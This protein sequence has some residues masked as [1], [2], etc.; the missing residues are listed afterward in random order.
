MAPGPLQRLKTQLYELYVRAHY[1]T[2]DTMADAVAADDALAG[3]PSRDSIRRY[4]SGPGRPDEYADLEALVTVLARAA[5]LDVPPVLA[6]AREHWLQAG[7][8][9]APAALVQPG[10]D[11]EVRA[12][13]LEALRRRYRV[14]ELST[15]TPEGLDE[16]LPIW[17]AQVFEPQ[18]VR[19]VPER[20]HRLP[21]LELPRDLR[22]RLLDSGDLTADELP[23]DLNAEQLEEARREHKRQ[24]A[25]PVLQALALAGGRAV[26]LGDPGAGKSTLLAYLALALAD[27]KIPDE[28]T[29]WS[30]R[31][32]LLVELREYAD[33]GWRIGRWAD[34]TLLDFLDHRYHH[35]G[36]GLP[37]EQLANH[38]R[39]DGRA[40]V[41]FDGLDELFDPAQRERTARAIAEFATRYPYVTVLVTSRPI[42]YQRGVLDAAR[43]TLHTVE[44]L[45]REQIT[46][47]VKRWYR[48]SHHGAP[49]EADARAS[50]LCAAL[51][52]SRS[53]ASLAGNPLLLTIL[54]IIGRRRELPR[55]RHRVYEHAVA[56][57]VQQWD[58]NRHLHDTRSG[59]ELDDTDRHRLLHRIAEHMQ[60]GRYGIAGNRIHRE[61]L[62]TTIRDYLTGD[63]A[64]PVDRSRYAG[65]VLIKQLRERNFILSRYGPGLFGFVHRAFLEYCTAASIT[66]RLKEDQTLSNEELAELFC[67]HATDPA[68]NEIL[69]LVAGMVHPNVLVPVLHRLLEHV[70]SPAGRIGRHN[71]QHLALALDCLAETRSITA[72]GV[73]GERLTTELLRSIQAGIEH[74]TDLTDYYGSN[75]LI[76]MTENALLELKQRLPGAD[77]LRAQ[78]PFILDRLRPYLTFSD[79][80]SLST[81]ERALH[82]DGNQLQSILRARAT[83]SDNESIQQAAVRALAS[84]WPDEHTRTWLTDWALTD[85]LQ[86]GVREATVQALASG[87]PDDRTRTLLT[88]RATTD[89]HEYV[90]G[91][92]VQELASNWP[93][94]RTRTLLTDR[95]TTDNHEYVR[96]IAVHEL[97][98]GWPDNHSRTLLTDRATTDNH[99]YVRGTAMQA[100]ASGWPDNHTRTLL[101]DRATT[102]NHEYVRATAMQELASGWPDNH[103]RTLLTDRATT[104]NHE[105]VRATAVQ[106][107]ASGWPDNHTRTLLTDQATTDT[108]EDVRRTA[109]Q[110]LASGWPDD[111]TRTLLTDRAIT[112][113]HEFVRGIAI[114]ELASGWPD[115]HTRTLLTDQATTDTHEDVRQTALQVL[116]SGWPDD[117]TRTLLTDR[118]TTDNDDYVR[119]TALRVLASGWPDDHTRTLLTDR[120]TTDN[121]G[122][123]R[124]TAVQELGSGWPDDHTR[125]LL[126]DRATTDDDEHVRYTATVTLRAGWPDDHTRALLTDRATTDDDRDVQETAL[127]ALTS[128]WPDDHTRALL[129]DRA[130]TDNHEDVRRRALRVLASGW[131]DDHTRALLIDRATTDNHEDVRQTAL[132]VLASG[133]PDDHTRALLTDRATTD[134]HEDAQDAAARALKPGWPEA[135]PPPNS[136]VPGAC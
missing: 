15:L 115:N 111:H 42:G 23:E 76:G 80:N 44:D 41:M 106:E 65:T 35:D 93:D 36:L 130:T 134:N 7:L 37:R 75:S 110:V 56:V 87:W 32:P 91:T 68:W 72:L 21:Q 124:Q 100:L 135:V 28:L 78:I 20:A 97:A 122:D 133:W 63:C 54:A 4:I 55:E 17:L 6:H 18:R 109:L 1:P 94:N 129:T 24:P 83:T 136:G 51:D 126:T 95:A 125:T 66:Y 64:Q 11:P 105:D 19:A 53:A 3:A 31:L 34:A 123:V 48:L 79:I 104:D 33:P 49:D 118:A 29:S 69:R 39:A 101:T 71:H 114:Q 62:L 84:G 88:D 9:P 47:F 99:E 90:R 46:T 127:Q 38:L 85:E 103:T 10:L 57:L 52:R 108:H 119:Q 89:N 30:G 2:L 131:P 102:D 13:Y 67:R 132:R 12:G 27:D 128:G 107:L 98:S 59:V 86:N 26:L 16:A 8:D 5:G 121:D 61:D 45:D 70:E 50:R 73:Q 22:Q 113:T 81:V 82:A 112:D 117:H 92:A 77:R 25:R 96:A 58:P 120:A 116:A 60:H 74:Y 40:V 14:L 43:F